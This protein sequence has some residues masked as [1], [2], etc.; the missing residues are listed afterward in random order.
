MTNKRVQYI[1]GTSTQTI[2]APTTGLQYLRRNSGNTGWELV[3]VTPGGG[4]ASLG[5]TLAI[6]NATDGYD[7]VLSVGDA[8]TSADGYVN[9]HGHLSVNNGLDVANK[10]ITSVK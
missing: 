2:P 5:T 1:E 7:I 6:G 4:T 3:T 8:L 10:K 9:I